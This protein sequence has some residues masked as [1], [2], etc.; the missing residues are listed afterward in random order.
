VVIKRL[1]KFYRL[2]GGLEKKF[3]YE[4]YGTT[5]PIARIDQELNLDLEN[6]VNFKDYIHESHAK[7][8]E[9]HNLLVPSIHN[10]WFRAKHENLPLKGL[11][12]YCHIQNMGEVIHSSEIG[13]EV[14]KEDYYQIRNHVNQISAC[15][16]YDEIPE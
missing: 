8:L 14:S 7:K 2:S 5:N 9:G 15:I 10:Y 3:F 6:I 13:E 11:F 16:V 4:K 12:F 1:K